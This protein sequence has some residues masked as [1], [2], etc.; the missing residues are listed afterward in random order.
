MGNYENLNTENLFDGADERD[1]GG[2]GEGLER[3][4]VSDADLDGQTLAEYA[5][6]QGR[7][8]MVY[9]HNGEARVVKDGI[10]YWVNP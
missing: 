9:V 6:K 8:D 10:A 1:D 4:A 5:L 7:E 3:Q 2:R